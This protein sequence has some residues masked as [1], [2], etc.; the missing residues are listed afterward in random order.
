MIAEVGQ[1]KDRI[2]I[3]RLADK[4][5]ARSKGQNQSA[6]ELKCRVLM[7]LHRRAEMLEVAKK[8]FQIDPSPRWRML[9]ARGNAF[10]WED[11]HD[12]GA[13]TQ[14]Y[15]L[16]TVYVN[17]LPQDPEGH[18]YLGWCLSHMGRRDS[19]KK[20]FERALELDPS[21]QFAREKM[22]YVR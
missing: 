20:E 14:V 13:L 4:V 3:L 17:E 12:P 22:E 2:E 19:A 1:D 11:A 21:D 10:R 16:L 15:K 18:D 5:L 6:L 9:L 8:G 7:G